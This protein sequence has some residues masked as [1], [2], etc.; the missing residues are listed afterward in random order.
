VNSLGSLARFALVVLT[1]CSAG[2]AL[3]AVEFAGVLIT[4]EKSLFRL[5]DD[6]S[7]ASPAWVKVGDTFAGHEILSFDAQRDTL[8]L[9]KDGATSAVRL[10]DSKVRPEA[11]IEIS[12]VATFGGDEKMEVSRATLL[13]DQENSFPLKQG[14]I[15]LITPTRLTDGSIRYRLVF[16]RPDADGDIELLSVLTLTQRAGDPLSFQFASEKNSAATATPARSPQRNPP[17][18]PLEN[19]P[20]ESPLQKTKP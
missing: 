20:R 10:K 12:G 13:M 8:T 7:G 1:L 16:E 14:I 9:R 11:S 17:T 3:A 5:K 19:P 4:S 15:C 2:R 18:T 6:S